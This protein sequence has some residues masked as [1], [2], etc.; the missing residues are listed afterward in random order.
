[1]DSRLR[2]NDK[3]RS[4]TTQSWVPVILAKRSPSFPR[5]RESIKAHPEQVFLGYFGLFLFHLGLEVCKVIRLVS[6]K[7]CKFGTNDSAIFPYRSI[8]YCFI[9]GG[10]YMINIVFSS[11]NN[12]ITISV[13][14]VMHNRVKRQPGT[15]LEFVGKMLIPQT[16]VFWTKMPPHPWFPQNQTPLGVYIA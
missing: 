8:H 10:L 15:S 7:T 6:P 12:W 11:L 1:M 3:E 16:V 9:H 13:Q 14:T 2:G 5:R 4:I